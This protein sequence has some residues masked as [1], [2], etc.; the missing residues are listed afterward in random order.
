MNVCTPS[1][2][3]AK[4]RKET[5]VHLA[6][7]ELIFAALLPQNLTSAFIVQSE[8]LVPDGVP[9]A[10]SNRPRDLRITSCCGLW[11]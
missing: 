6:Q 3:D 5:S 8:S 11:R 9:A 1:C 7:E 2:K 4:Q 10:R